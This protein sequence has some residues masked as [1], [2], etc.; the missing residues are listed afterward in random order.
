MSN[1]HAMPTGKRTYTLAILF[2]WEIVAKA[3]V[4]LFCSGSFQYQKV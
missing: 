3:D 1:M 4:D 2:Y